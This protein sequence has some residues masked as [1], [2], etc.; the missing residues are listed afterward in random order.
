MTRPAWTPL[1]AAQGSGHAQRR[2]T[3]PV[4]SPGQVAAILLARV[5]DVKQKDLS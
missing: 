1:H 4:L 2:W 3:L 5:G